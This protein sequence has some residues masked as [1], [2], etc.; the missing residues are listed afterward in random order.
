MVEV[1]KE[2]VMFLLLV[3]L[4]LPG[5]CA[6]SASD[7]FPPIASALQDQQ[8]EKAL[9]LLR[10]AL[11]Q[12]PRDAELWTMQGKA[13]SGLGRKKEALTS[14]RTALEFS[15]D[16]LLALQGAAQ[17]EY[18]SGSAAGIPLLRHLLLLRPG[19]VTSH[20]MLAVLEYQQGNCRAAVPH[21]ERAAALFD[22]RV[23]ALHAYATCLVRLKQI[24]KA[25]GV[26]Q[27]ALVLDPD[28]RRERQVLASLLLMAHKPEGA[29]AT[30]DPLLGT[31]ADPETLE[32]A[33]RAYE[34]THDTTRAVDA[35]RQ[36]ILLHP[37]DPNLYVDFAILSAAHQSFQVGINVVNEGIN[38]QPKAAAL[39]FARGVLYVQLAD[40]GKAQT[41]FETAYELDPTQSLS[42]AAQGL[43]AVQQNDLLR[44]L[45][46]VQEKLV[47]KPADPILLYLQADILTQKGAEPGSAD[48][49][50]AMR[51][52]KKAVALRP[53][54][55]PARSV[56][57]KLYLE[58]GQY[59]EAAAQCRK[60]LEIDPKDQ[61]AL[62]HLIQALRKTE[63]KGQI[64]ELLKSLAMLRQ[65]ATKDEREQ[66]RYKLVEGDAQP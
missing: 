44:A 23:Q 50:M 19:D 4:V 64:P 16:N 54:L 56:L 22:S 21:F 32:L 12:S 29:L 61:S 24:D 25:A 47:R 58:S 51:S 59:P 33:S 30:L 60:A 7:H 3:L 57:A 31:T 26:L 39:F 43:A 28:D 2:D 1:E 42:A 9:E 66:Y 11:Q 65:Q 45:A 17:I 35:L 63:N 27:R 15:P 13:Y 34:N 37:Q 62:Y 46:G 40:F 6:Q 49:Q 8:F 36:A 20:G 41:D 10:S 52:A 18:D 5:A 48:F 38:M 14:F 53:A 55:G